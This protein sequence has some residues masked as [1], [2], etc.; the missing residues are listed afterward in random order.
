[1]FST[2]LGVLPGLELAE[3]TETGLELLATGR[4]PL[5]ADA[6]PA[7]VV[8]TWGAAAAATDRPVKQV[9][10]GP[11]SAGRDGSRGRPSELADS[12]RASVV[13]L[14]DAGCSFVEIDEPDALAIAHVEGERRRFV[15]AHR[16]LLDGIG[17]V[18][19]SLAVTGG[20]LDTAGP[21]TFFDL[22]YASYAFD[23]IA[24]PENWRLVVAAPG[25]RGIV[26]G[27]LSAKPDGDETR[28][29]LLWAAQ[30]AASTN[31]R[32]I[33]RVGLAN[34]P[35]LAALPPDVALRKLG[36][37]AEAVRIGSMASSG[38][39]AK[40]LDPRALG[41]RGGRA[42]RVRLAGRGRSEHEG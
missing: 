37:I 8:A 12:L 31:G 30:Y 39:M 11:Y 21:A 10:A 17:D 5:G 15:D 13:A 33:E 9:L 3:L 19:V 7:D 14:R 35:S 36:R 16:R 38:E 25:D 4:P 27:A 40:L 26:C 34:A 42:R 28:E 41:L 18:H 22:P 1:M 20:N 32:G 23:L 29:L 2:V 6:Q 24:G